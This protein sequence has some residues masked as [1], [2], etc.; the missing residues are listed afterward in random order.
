MRATRTVPRLGNASTVRCANLKRQPGLAR[1]AR[2]EQRDQPDIAAGEQRADALH[3]GST[4]D[5]RVGGGGESGKG[6]RGWKWRAWRVAGSARILFLV[7][8]EGAPAW[9]R[10]R[11]RFRIRSEKRGVVTE[12]GVFE[13]PQIRPRLQTDLIERRTRLAVRGERLGMTAA[14]IQRQ[15]Q[16]PAGLLAQRIRGDQFRDRPDHLAMPPQRKL[17]LSQ[18][19]GRG[20]TQLIQ[21]GSLSSRPRRS[22]PFP[23]APTP[24]RPA[25]ALAT[26]RAPP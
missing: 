12:D 13:S 11:F 15:H 1:P 6:R 17:G 3:L 21:P 23:P 18:A 22:R 16:Q 20:R 9:V 8:F 5:Q 7:E 25:A 26:A 10:N 2:A 24:T 4:P 19:L 14:P